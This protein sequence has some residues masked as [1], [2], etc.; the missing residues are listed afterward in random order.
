MDTQWSCT[1]VLL[2][3][4]TAY[5]SA[6]VEVMF[7]ILIDIKESKKCVEI[8]ETSCSDCI[9]KTFIMQY[10]EKCV[11]G[12]KKNEVSHLGY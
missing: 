1:L 12:P 11:F 8:H 7:K 3:F 2:Y 6:G 5:D 4:K 9:T 10:T